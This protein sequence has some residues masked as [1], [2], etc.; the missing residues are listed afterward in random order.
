L[1]LVGLRLPPSFHERVPSEIG[2]SVMK[3]G[4]SIRTLKTAERLTRLVMIVTLATASISKFWSHGRFAEYY[5]GAFTADK[6][7]IHLPPALIDGYLQIV[8]FI[9]MTI[10]VALVITRL[11]PYSV[12]AWFAFFL[13]LE[14]G[15][16]VLEE[17]VERELDDSVLSAGPVLP[18]PAQPPQLVSL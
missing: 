6:L 17:W 9:E 18:D 10:A 5:F 16:Y 7:R 13:S 8:P 11:K 14:V 2:M 4:I 1:G 15:H 3:S 12:Y